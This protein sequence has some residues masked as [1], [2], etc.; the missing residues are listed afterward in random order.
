MKGIQEREG[1]LREDVRKRGKGCG[2][3]RHAGAK[4]RES[5]T[6]RERMR[7][8]VRERVRE[9]GRERA[10]NLV[11]CDRRPGVMCA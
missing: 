4:E 7:E 9:R 8:R 2:R 10:Q 5:R 3:N 11:V 1:G 6:G